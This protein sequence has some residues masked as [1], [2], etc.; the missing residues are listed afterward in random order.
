MTSRDSQFSCIWGEG[1]ATNTTGAIDYS[2]NSISGTSI[3]SNSVRDPQEATAQE[4]GREDRV[5][6]R[7]YQALTDSQ[8]GNGKARIS[9][10]RIRGWRELSK[11]RVN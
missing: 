9:L 4:P 1:V 6:T 3:S 10:G 7:P 5:S 8:A 11:Y 2:I